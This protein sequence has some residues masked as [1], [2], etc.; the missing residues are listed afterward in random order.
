MKLARWTLVGVGIVAGML[1]LL[2]LWYNASYLRVGLTG[3][4]S[5]VVKKYNI[6]HFYGAYYTMTA[7]CVLCHL[8]LLFCGVQLVRMRTRVFPFFVGVLAFEVAYFLIIMAVCWTL[9]GL[10][11]SVGAAMGVANG[12]LVLQAIIAF[13]LWAP[14]AAGWAKGRITSLG[15]PA[16]PGV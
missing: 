8:L 16:S 4:F 11:P 10:G 12:G 6:P 9:P 5:E 7:V 1:A 15:N 14:F 2:G 3:G 13:P